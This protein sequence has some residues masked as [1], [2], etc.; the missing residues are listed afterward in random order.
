MTYNVHGCVGMDGRLAPERIARIIADHDPDVVAL[1]ELDA[2]RERS[3]GVDQAAVI[4]RH[5]EMALAF[6]PAIQVEEERYGDAILSRLPM[7]L[8]KAALLPNPPSSLP[9]E[10]RGALWVT[11]EFDG[12]EIQVFNTHLGLL[13]HLRRFQA[14]ALASADWLA[15]PDCRPPVVLCGDFNALPNSPTCRLLSGRLRDV[16]S[17]RRRARST[18]GGSL[19][20]MRID[21]IFVDPATA[22]AGT[23]VPRSALARL[24]SDHLPLIADLRLDTDRP[25][26]AETPAHSSARARAGAGGQATSRVFS[27]K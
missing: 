6:H 21:H 9:L 4:A 13:P 3:N 14:E 22:V 12:V 20:L 2:G 8:V 1:Q 15:H 23:T 10:P 11:V 19:P 27:S 16:E 18:Y 7:R 17:G 25:V 26:D 5:L 24:A